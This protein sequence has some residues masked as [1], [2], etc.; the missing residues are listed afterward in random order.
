MLLLSATMG[1]SD[2]PAGASAVSR[3]R[4]P[5]VACCRSVAPDSRR[6]RMGRTGAFLTHGYRTAALRACGASRRVMSGSLPA[7]VRGRF[8][9]M[10]DGS[11]PSSGLAAARECVPSCVSPCAGVKS[12]A[13]SSPGPPLKA[14]APVPPVMVSLPLSPRR[15]SLPSPP[16]SLSLACSPSRMSFPLPPLS[17]VVA[18]AAA[19]EVV[20]GGPRGA[21]SCRCVRRSCR[22]PPVPLSVSLWSLPT[23]TVTTMVVV[24]GAVAQTERQGGATAPSRRGGHRQRPAVS[25]PADHHGT[26]HERRIAVRSQRRER[27]CLRPGRRGRG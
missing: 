3:H 24:R 14:S 5:N 18:V 10:A 23:I 16:S 11:A 25:G 1:G 19:E 13:T 27:A 17:D 26:G 2:G 4:R 9:A 20:A 6:L 15:V 21:C 7:S 8:R 12:D 22:V